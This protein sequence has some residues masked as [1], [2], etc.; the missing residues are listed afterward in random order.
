MHLF[1]INAL[2][3]VFDFD[4][5]YMYQTHTSA[6]KTAYTDACTTW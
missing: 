4:V 2:F 6:Y 1:W 5:F 3:L